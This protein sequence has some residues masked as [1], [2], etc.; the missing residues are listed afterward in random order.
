LADGALLGS[1]V[2]EA[3]KAVARQHPASMTWA[4]FQCYGDP[5]YRLVSKER[6]GRATPAFVSARELLRRIQTVHVLAGKIGLPDFEDIAAR[7]GELVDELDAYRKLVEE[8]WPTPELLYDLG[9][10]YAELGQ[11]EPAVEIYRF[12]A[13]GPDSSRAPVKLFEQLASFEMRLAHQL[14]RDGAPT[15]EGSRVAALIGAARDRLAGVLHLGETGERF[16]LLASLHK[17]VATIVG[18]G[19]QRAAELAA[20]ADSYGRAHRYHLDR[21]D[22]PGPARLSSLYALNWLQLASLAGI[23]VTTGEAAIVLEAFLASPEAAAVYVDGDGT[24]LRATRLPPTA[25]RDDA[26][27]YWARVA[28]ADALL[29]RS[30]IER[31]FDIAELEAA[32]RV[33]FTTRSTRRRRMSTTEHLRDMAVLCSTPDLAELADRL[34]DLSGDS[35]TAGQR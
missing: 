22:R 33:P 28:R 19:P 5:G 35:R 26:D 34:N 14:W 9:A 11:F 3:R 8:Q 23:D 10:A 29:T 1:A 6:R 18:E 15:G 13:A 27:A 16:T 17:K 25:V 21:C 30:V 32:Y 31:S 2:H 20:A 7:E 24:V 12:T 4:A